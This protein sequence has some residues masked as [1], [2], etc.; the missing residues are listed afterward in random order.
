MKT[1]VLQLA[2][3]QATVCRAFG[4]SRRLIILWSIASEELSVHEIAERVGSSLQNVSQHLNLLKKT[5]IVISRR[6]G[7]TIYYRIADQDF[8]TKCP[9]ML[10]APK[11][12]E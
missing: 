11:A 12:L 4:N 7:Q 2:E 8:L 3:E 1:D 6:E 9:A 10:R 5:G